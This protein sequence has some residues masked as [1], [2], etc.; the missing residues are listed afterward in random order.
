MEKVKLVGKNSPAAIGSYSPG[1]K[2]GNMIF[3]T[4]IGL[5]ADGKLVS[6]DIA[7]Q[8][9][10]AMKNIKAVLAAGGAAMDNIVKTTIILTDINDFT[11]VND[12][13]KEFF[14]EPYPARSTMQAVA[15]PAKVKIMI[16]VIAQ[17]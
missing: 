12:V 5:T 10:Q 14:T 6:D 11:A 13:Y 16:D 1:V 3:I 15:L 4:Q 7:E 8:T 2:A 17:I 9:E